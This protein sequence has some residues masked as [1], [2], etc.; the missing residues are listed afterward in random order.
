MSRVNHLKCDVC[1]T[2]I[3]RDWHLRI[4]RRLF[5]GLVVKAYS[6]GLKD[7]TPPYE[8]WRTNRVDICSDCWVDVLETVREE[9][10]D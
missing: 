5:W 6:W 10:N 4:K 3:S 8:G 9:T 2:V 1:D 7:Y